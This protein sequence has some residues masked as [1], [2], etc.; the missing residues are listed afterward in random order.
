MLKFSIKNVFKFETVGLSLSKGDFTNANL[1]TLLLYSPKFFYRTIRKTRELL[2]LDISLLKLKLSSKSI[3]KLISRSSSK[4]ISLRSSFE[5]DTN[6]EY[7]VEFTKSVSKFTLFIKASP[8]TQ[9]IQLLSRDI[10]GVSTKQ[11]LPI[12]NFLNTY[13]C[14]A[15]GYS[16]KFRAL[17]LIQNC[18]IKHLRRYLLI[19]G[20]HTS[21]LWLSGLVSYF[22]F[23][24]KTLNSPQQ[25]IYSNPLSGELI[26]D[27]GFSKSLRSIN[28]SNQQLS[29]L[30]GVL[31]DLKLERGL[32]IEDQD[33]ILWLW[34]SLESYERVEI[35]QALRTGRSWQRWVL[36][37][38]EIVFFPKQN[39]GFIKT[40]KARSIKRRRTKI[41]VSTTKYR[42]W[43]K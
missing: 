26:G 29:Y 34:N 38:G 14:S 4:A 30:R 27:I 33:N 21:N 32:D 12:F 39:H 7:F 18:L 25:E 42:F 31:E 16:K 5:F 3:R 28:S 37:W 17:N 23:Y 9:S 22:N 13:I 43:P 36:A 6:K 35:G 15:F 1:M 11:T 2:L 10:R 19:L 8:K 41:L 40:R 24:W 20:V